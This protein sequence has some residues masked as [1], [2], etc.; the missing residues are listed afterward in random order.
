M[1]SF[2]LLSVC[3][4]W[5]L[6][7]LTTLSFPFCSSTRGVCLLAAGGDPGHGGW[8]PATEADLAWSLLYVSKACPVLCLA[9]LCFL[10]DSNTK[11]WWEEVLGLLLLVTGNRATCWII[12]MLI[13]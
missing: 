10:G 2:V 11:I 9:A 3:V 12:G 13:R 5:H 6:A 1:G 8:V 7:G 4:I